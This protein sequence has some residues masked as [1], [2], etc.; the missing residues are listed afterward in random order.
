VFDIRHMPQGC[1]TWPAAWEVDEN[2]WPAHGEV[3]VVE[4]ANDISPNQVTLHMSPGCTQ[5]TNR[6]MQ[7]C[8]HANSLPYQLC[9][10]H[11]VAFPERHFRPT[12]TRT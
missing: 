8:A 11:S 5:P 12:A 6:V 4:G 10:D 1:G 7:G 2:V 3:D 9:A